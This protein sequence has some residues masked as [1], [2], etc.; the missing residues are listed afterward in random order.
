MNIRIAL[1]LLFVGL[2][3]AAKAQAPPPPI[4]PAW[5]FLQP[6]PGFANPSAQARSGQLATYRADAPGNVVMLVTTVAPGNSYVGTQLVWV[7]SRGRLIMTKDYA[8]T[9][10]FGIIN[11]SPST[12]TISIEV[13]G[14]LTLQK[15]TRAGARVKEK[16]LAVTNQALPYSSTQGAFDASGYLLTDGTLDAATNYTRLR[17]QRFR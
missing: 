13:N 3:F 2:P 12:I 1:L 10:T 16:E 6:V 15:F 7:S 11:V 14:T 8:V 9:A 5:T 17:V 4:T